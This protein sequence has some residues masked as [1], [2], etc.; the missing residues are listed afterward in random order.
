MR[1]AA[2]WTPACL[3]AVLVLGACG[4]APKLPTP[5]ENK[6]H[7]VNA[8]MAV[9]LQQGQSSL[10]NAR[11]AAIESSRVAWNSAAML[12][13]VSARQRAADATSSASNAIFVIPFTYGSSHPMLTV[14]TAKDLIA[15]A[16]AAPLVLVRGRAGTSNST[17]ASRIARRRVVAVRDHL[18]QAGVEP[19]HIRITYQPTTDIAT[20]NSAASSRAMNRQVE[21]EIYRAMP[22]TH[23]D[24]ACAQS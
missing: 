7:P 23:H 24:M 5:D 3:C 4:S 8:P 2:T 14:D 22:V 20:D 19:G 10:Q 1:L 21:L 13:R 12:E 18:I 17:A 15:Q 16:R 6:R 11:I 9:E